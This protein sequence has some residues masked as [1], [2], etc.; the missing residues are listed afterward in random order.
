MCR[1]F[2]VCAIYYRFR[3]S[4]YQIH[5]MTIRPTNNVFDRVTARDWDPDRNDAQRRTTAHNGVL[6]PK[7]PIAK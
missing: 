1:G 5:T 2:E 6:Y 7:V 3:L 4:R